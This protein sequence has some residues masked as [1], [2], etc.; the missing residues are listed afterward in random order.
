M[1]EYADWEKINL[2]LFINLPKNKPHRVTFQTLQSKMLSDSMPVILGGVLGG[3]FIDEKEQWWIKVLIDATTLI[4]DRELWDSSFSKIIA[5]EN[6]G[7]ESPPAEGLIDEMPD[8][9]LRSFLLSE[10]IAPVITNLPK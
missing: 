5:A 7:L 8:P 2:P 1:T 10:V 3:V 4:T 6:E 9:K